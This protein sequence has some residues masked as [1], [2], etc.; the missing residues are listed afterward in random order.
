MLFNRFWILISFRQGCQ[1]DI[2]S[3]FYNHPK[4]KLNI[5]T[6]EYDVMKLFY[7]IIK[8]IKSLRREHTKGTVKNLLYTEKGNSIYG[9]VVRGIS[10]KRVFLFFN[11]K[12]F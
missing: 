3:A 12:K 8:N 5:N 11:W 9:N 1:I 2:K 4:E 7:G 6:N 10:N